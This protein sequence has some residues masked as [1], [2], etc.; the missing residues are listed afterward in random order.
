MNGQGR[1]DLHTATTRD[2]EL[3]VTITDN[4]SGIASKDLPHVFE[5]FYTT[6]ATG[7]G[8]GLAVVHGIIKEHGGEVH[9]ESKAGQGT[10]IRVHLPITV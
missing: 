7:T 6:K 8:L 5:P 3:T 1:L 2:G 4:G 9:V 10:S